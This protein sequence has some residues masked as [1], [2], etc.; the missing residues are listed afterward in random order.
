[1]KSMPAHVGGGDETGQIAHHPAA[2]GDDEV[3]TRE[4]VARDGL[5][6]LVCQLD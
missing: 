3:V 5:P 6:Q 1:M 2:T 4:A